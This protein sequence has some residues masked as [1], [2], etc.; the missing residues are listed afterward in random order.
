VTARDL[1]A[2]NVIIVLMDETCYG[3]PSGKAA[4]P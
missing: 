3:D 4:L 1:L 2:P